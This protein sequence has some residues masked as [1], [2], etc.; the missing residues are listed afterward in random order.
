M[1]GAPRAFY[2]PGD[3]VFLYGDLGTGKTQFVKFFAEHRGYAASSPSYGLVHHYG[4]I[5]HM[6]LYRLESKEALE[7]I[8][9]DDILSDD[10]VKFIEWPEPLEEETPDLTLRLSYGGA[11]R[12]L[13]MEGPIAERGYADCD[14]SHS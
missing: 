1:G 9:M 2:H 14:C 5:T 10:T 6:D 3:I 8:G 4:D 12:I 7:T 13:E 11:G